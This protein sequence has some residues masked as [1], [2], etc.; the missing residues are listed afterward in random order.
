MQFVLFLQ[1]FL[2]VFQGLQTWLLSLVVIVELVVFQWILSPSTSHIP[3]TATLKSTILFYVTASRLIAEAPAK[4]PCEWLGE[5]WGVQFCPTLSSP[6]A[7]YYWTRLKTMTDGNLLLMII[8]RTTKTVC[9]VAHLCS[10]H[11]LSYLSFSE[12]PLYQSSLQAYAEKFQSTN[13][14]VS[15]DPNS[16]PSLVLTKEMLYHS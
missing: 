6:N 12:H 3:I 14:T 13:D 15:I 8:L 10:W 16:P 7:W 1:T 4:S 9:Q 2:M 11:S 5:L